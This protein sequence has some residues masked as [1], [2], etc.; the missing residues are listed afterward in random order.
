[1]TRSYRWA[2]RSGQ[3]GKRV[4]CAGIVVGA[5]VT[6]GLSVH[7][8]LQLTAMIKSPASVKRETDRFRLEEC[9][10]HTVRSEVPKGATTYDI[11]PNQV[12]TQW[13]TGLSTLWAVPQPSPATARWIL[14]LVPAH[15]D[16]GGYALKVRHT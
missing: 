10:Y 16:C 4:G 15:G 3:V 11:G 7:H 2:G 8:D 13:V 5:A 6:L 14:T 1:M 12:L 9:I